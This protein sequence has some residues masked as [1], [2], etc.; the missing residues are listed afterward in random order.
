MSPF[1]PR[2]EDTCAVVAFSGIT[3]VLSP[4]SATKAKTSFATKIT[5]ADRST[6][7][8]NEIPTIRNA[9]DAPPFFI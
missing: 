1:F 3:T 9:C 7:M 8:R 5:A 2:I 4:D 6:D